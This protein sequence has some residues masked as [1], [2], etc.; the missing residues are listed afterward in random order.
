MPPDRSKN[1]PGSFS[2][3]PL[4]LCLTNQQPLTG[5]AGK[6]GREFEGL[7]SKPGKGKLFMRW[8]ALRSRYLS[9]CLLGLLALSFVPSAGAAD[10]AVISKQVNVNRSA[11]EVWKRVGGYCS[12]SEWLKM[13]CDLV[14]GTGDVGSVRRLN[15]T[16]VEVMVA[17]TPY[18]YTYWQTAGT[19]AQ[20]SYHGT[21]A[22]EPTGKK[23][24]RLLYTLF[25]DQS[26]LAS[27]ALRSSEHDRLSGRFQGA[28][29]TMKG[30]AESK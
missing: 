16:T 22:V 5:S 8:I 7:R 2:P 25:Y 6:G 10:Y 15:G 26:A 1:E 21:L 24:S 19:M 18:S 30:L 11:D 9:V 14:S 27:D 12:I 23:T 20:T 4:V 17:K 3:R 29:D 28:L 13:S